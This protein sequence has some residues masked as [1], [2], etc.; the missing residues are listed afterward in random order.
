MG[1]DRRGTKID[2]RELPVSL[3]AANLQLLMPE[4][5]PA[6]QSMRDAL[7]RGP[8][9]KQKWSN[10]RI[11]QGFCANTD[12]SAASPTSGRISPSEWHRK[13]PEDSW[14]D[15]DWA[16]SVQVSED[17]LLSIHLARMGRDIRAVQKF[18]AWFPTELQRLKQVKLPKLYVSSDD[19][20]LAYHVDF[21]RIAWMMKA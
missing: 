9:S 16:S 14:T 17:G 15:V 7:G 11:R 21:L 20:E 5:Q 1:A 18:C 12:V 4:D 8:T 13:G 3:K 6:A 10:N 19:I 2:G